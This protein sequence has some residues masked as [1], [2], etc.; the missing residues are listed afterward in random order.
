MVVEKQPVCNAVFGRGGN[1]HKLKFTTRKRGIRNSS[2]HLCSNT[3]FM[4]MDNISI[5]TVLG[6]D[7]RSEVLTRKN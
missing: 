3:S 1:Y 5:S 2:G 7:R 6:S 4:A